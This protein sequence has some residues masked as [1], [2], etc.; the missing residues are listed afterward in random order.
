MYV[1]TG[2]EALG[3]R[4]VSVSIFGNAV[5]KWGKKFKMGI[6]PLFN[7]RWIQTSAKGLAA[8]RDP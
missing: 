8:K 1:L 5:E 2:L 7:Y 6:S 3:I 4:S